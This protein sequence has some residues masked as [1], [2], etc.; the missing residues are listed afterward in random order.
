MQS[1]FFLKVTKSASLGYLIPSGVCVPTCLSSAHVHG[2][3]ARQVRAPDELALLP[4][5]AP[6]RLAAGAR[7]LLDQ[8]VEACCGG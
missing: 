8:D 6:H 3:A 5:Q 2:R 7:R 4:Q 1:H